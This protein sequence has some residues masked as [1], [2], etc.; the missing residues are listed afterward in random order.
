MFTSDC[1]MMLT[2]KKNAT[3]YN[4]LTIIGLHTT[5][6]NMMLTNMAITFNTEKPF[7]FKKQT[8]NKRAPQMY[9]NIK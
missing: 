4:N 1:S 9:K 7:V 5:S 8:L 3:I 6:I 2:I